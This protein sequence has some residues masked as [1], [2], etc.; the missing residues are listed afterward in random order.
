[1]DLHLSPAEQSLRRWVARAGTEVFQPLADA[2]GERDE[3]NRELVRAMGAGG[4]FPLL[5]PVAYGGSLDDPFRSMTLCLVREELARTCP[6]A[7]ALFAIQGLGSYPILSAGTEAQKRRHLPPLARG[8]E[9]PAFALTEPEAGSDAAGLTTCAVR[10][11]DG[12]VLSGTKR[13]ISNAPVADLYVVFAKTAPDRGAKGIS[14]FLVPQTTPGLSGVPLHT[15]APHVIGELSFDDCHLAAE[16]LLGTEHDGWRL[17]MGTLDVFRASVGAQAVGLAQ[18]AFDLA[19]AHART[20]VQFGQPI[21]QFQ[22]V[23]AKLADMATEIR[24][25]RLLVH[26]AARLKDAGA[27]RV[28]L[29]SSMAKLYATEMA[30][31][32][33]D[34]AVQIHGG[35]GLL[36]GSPIERLYRE[37]RAPRIYEGTSEI[38]RLIIARQLLREGHGPV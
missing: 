34:Q 38:Q 10:D 30:H 5:V 7:E 6:A 11:G 35:A 17:A 26:A 36:R 3:L 23:Q 14:A 33:V 20:R 9:V 37:A 13:F 31:R 29:E 4:V 21:G 18:A 27:A 1:M 8:A 15:M 16:S 12:F 2:W 25:A 19:L 32:V 22:L 28:T 24:A